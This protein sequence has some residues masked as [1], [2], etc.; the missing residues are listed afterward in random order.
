[1][2]VLEALVAMATLALALSL[3]TTHLSEVAAQFMA[4][5]EAF[6]VTAK[7]AALTVL[8]LPKLRGLRLPGHIN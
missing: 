1:M 8:C 5:T 6:E 4:V 7:A 3:S 2:V